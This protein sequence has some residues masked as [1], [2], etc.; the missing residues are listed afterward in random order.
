MQELKIK[1]GGKNLGFSFGLGFLGE[2][3]EELNLGLDSLMFK[4]SNNPFKYIPELMYLSSKYYY[5]LNGEEFNLTKKDVYS[6]L[7]KESEGINSE[8]SLKFVKA[9]ADSITKHVPKTE[10]IEED[11]EEKK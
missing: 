8:P 2:A 6:L 4:I 11:S 3:L 9:L 1:L 5:E 7:E 10:A